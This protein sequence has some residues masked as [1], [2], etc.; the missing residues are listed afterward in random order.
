MTGVQTCA[1]PIYL[2]HTP[3]DGI[4]Y[5]DT[6]A[7]GLAHLGDW[8]ATPADPYNPHE[9]VDS[10]AAAI[11]A[12]GLLR[13]GRRLQD[14]GYWNAGLKVSDT[15]FDEPYLSTDP[16][17]QGLILHSVY[18][19][20]NGWDLIPANSKVPAGESSMWGDYHARELGLYLERLI[21]GKPYLKFW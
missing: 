15:L 2:A 4:P 9:P 17:H 1:L 19:R 5:W 7:P 11:A 20:P 21:E 18:H 16:N 8:R 12:Q 13:L 14:D 10:S 6:G 3:P